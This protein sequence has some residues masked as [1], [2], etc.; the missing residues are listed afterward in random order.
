METRSRDRKTKEQMEQG[1]TQKDVV[2]QME[3]E[4]EVESMEMEDVSDEVAEELEMTVQP[5]VVDMNVILSILNRSIEE[6]NRNFK[7]INDKFDKQDIK[8]ENVNQKLIDLTVQTEKN[9]TILNDKL[10]AQ[11]IEMNNKFLEIKG[12]YIRLEQKENDLEQTCRILE[13]KIEITHS[14]GCR[15][16]EKCKKICETNYLTLDQKVNVRIDQIED[17]IDEVKTNSS[18]IYDRIEDSFVRMNDRVSINSSILK[19]QDNTIKN[20]DSIIKNKINQIKPELSNQQ[21]IILPPTL[22]SGGNS[23]LQ[24]FG[25]HEKRP[26]QFLK[27]VKNL[28][29]TYNSNWEVVKGIIE[30]KLERKALAW[31][32]YEEELL[33]DMDSFEERFKYQYWNHEIQNKILE[34]IKYGKFNENRGIDKQTYF[35]NMVNL[36]KE[37]EIPNSEEQMIRYLARHFD[38]PIQEQIKYRNMNKYEMVLNYMRTLDNWEINKS[39]R[40][41]NNYN[42]SYN[43]KKAKENSHNY[44]NKPFHR[45]RFFENR[46]GERGETPH[47][48]IKFQASRSPNTSR[49]NRIYIDN[50]QKTRNS[51]NKE[52]QISEEIDPKLAIAGDDFT[53]KEENDFQERLIN[54]KRYDPIMKEEKEAERQDESL[55]AENLSCKKKLSHFM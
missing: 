3:L 36:N 34:E 50:G 22:M 55:R 44:G 8:L 4:K 52:R 19:E 20:I 32:K 26:L 39:T 29:K 16:L 38:E 46:Q 48:N 43:E 33:T 40:P 13:E 11:K 2:E 45:D 12:E 49:A 5:I 35:Y 23:N 30:N 10:D 27:Q 6:Q 47:K 7:E 25:G 14:E 53:P 18:R 1:E 42:P 31:F 17:S 28:Y 21:M 24:A 54:L 37:L 41:Q 15:E 9:Y 51:N